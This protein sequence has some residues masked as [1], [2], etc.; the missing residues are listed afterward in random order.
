MKIILRHRKVRTQRVSTLIESPMFD[1][2]NPRSTAEKALIRIGYHK[3]RFIDEDSPYGM[4]IYFR[5]AAIHEKKES[6]RHKAHVAH[7]K[8]SVSNHFVMVKQG[9]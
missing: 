1:I 7:C 2:Y 3:R 4:L 8:S 6:W 5:G 9:G